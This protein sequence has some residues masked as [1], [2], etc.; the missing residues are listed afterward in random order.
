[1]KLFRFSISAVI[2]IIANLVPLYGALFAGWNVFSI[3][4]LYWLE[5][6]IIGLF[7]ILKMNKAEGSIIE[8]VG[9]LKIA[10]STLNGRSIRELSQSPFSAKT[11]FIPFFFMH[12]GMFMLVHLIF[13]VV[14]FGVMPAA[15]GTP[16]VFDL[17]GITLGFLS[18][19][20][21]HAVSYKTNFIDQQEYKVVSVGQLFIS[22]YPR[23]IVMHL[24]IILGGMLAMSTGQSA[25]GLAL[26][27]VL[28]IIAD[29]GSHLFEHGQIAKRLL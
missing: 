8:Q 11:F 14:F 7:N 16:H 3:M 19:L 17:W 6:A 20:L 22:P 28:K 2:L 23:I 25:T 18:L 21:S 12:Y 1:M 27:I 5:S 9:G 29:L 10:E 13:L 15:N 4:I 24:T 26:L